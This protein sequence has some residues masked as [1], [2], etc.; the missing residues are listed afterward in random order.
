LRYINHFDL[1]LEPGEG[2]SLFLAMSPDLPQALP[3]GVSQF[4]IRFT[5]L[6]QALAIATNV[7]QA[8]QGD[9]GPRVKV[10]LDIDVYKIL[11]PPVGNED[12]LKNIFSMLRE[13]KNR[14]FFSLLTERCL[15]L[16]Q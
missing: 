6:E 2:F 9:P 15:Q 13:L 12:E 14:V 16:F 11:A 10:L 8:L 5:V 7:T 1:P 4:L 3:Q